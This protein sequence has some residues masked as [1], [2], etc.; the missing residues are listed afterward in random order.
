VAYVALASGFLMTDMLQ[1]R[2]LL[3]GGYTG[4]VAFHSLHARPLKIP[5]MWSALFV[6]VNAGAAAFLAADRYAAPFTAEEEELYQT[7]F[8]EML[9]RGQFSQ[10]L[11]L[12][13]RQYMARG[14][15][16]TQENTICPTLYFLEAGQARVFHGNSFVSTIERG[17]FVNDVAFSQG[18]A[19]GAYGTIVA[20]EDCSIWVWNTEELRQH[21]A[22]RPDM[23]RNMKFCL[24]NHLVKSLLRQREAAH[25]RQQQSLPQQVQ[26][27]LQLQMQPQQ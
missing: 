16:L 27:P 1:L 25:A 13:Q 6:L 24:S 26:L 22:T 15:I 23:E 9:T 2:V 11:K 20:S 3:V 5:L 8:A 19:V 12:G 21:L 4:L 7:H 10:L 18:A 14:S 17:G